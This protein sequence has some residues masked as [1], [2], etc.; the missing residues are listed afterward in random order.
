M[1]VQKHYKNVLQKNRVEEVLEKIGGKNQNRTFLGF[2]ITCTW[3]FLG[4][5]RAKTRYKTSKNI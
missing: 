2:F 3:A 5:G 1:G 4:E